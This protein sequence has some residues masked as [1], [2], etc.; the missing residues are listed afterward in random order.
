LLEYQ[1]MLLRLS[2]AARQRLLQK[3]AALI[4]NRSP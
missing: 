1:G 3:T 2:E 4:R